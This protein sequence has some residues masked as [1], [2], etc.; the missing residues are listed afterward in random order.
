MATPLLGVAR[1]RGNPRSLLEGKPSRNGLPI[2]SLRTE[3][4]SSRLL[5]RKMKNKTVGWGG[6][7][8]N[9]GRKPD[10]EEKKTVQI[11]LTVDQH[12]KLKELGGSKWISEQ[13]DRA[14]TNSPSKMH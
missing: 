1:G 10:T 14:M 6:L 12:R 13:I 11:R 5:L 9:A 4:R 3:P 7:R 8:P 2:G